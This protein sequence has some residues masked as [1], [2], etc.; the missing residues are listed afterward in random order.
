M[1]WKVGIFLDYLEIKSSYFIW[2]I[3]KVYWK[4]V[5]IVVYIFGNDASDMFKLYTERTLSTDILTRIDVSITLKIEKIHFLGPI[6]TLGCFIF[7]RKTCVKLTS[8]FGFHLRK[9]VMLMILWCFTAR[10]NVDYSFP[11]TF[12]YWNQRTLLEG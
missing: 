7:T 12:S 10:I 2:R 9:L 11:R 8:N 4:N 1:H 5:G 3:W 6:R